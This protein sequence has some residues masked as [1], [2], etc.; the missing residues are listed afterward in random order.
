[1]E[2]IAPPFT[3]AAIVEMSAPF[4]FSRDLLVPSRRPIH[5]ERGD[6]DWQRT[7]TVRLKKLD[8]EFGPALWL[9]ADAVYDFTK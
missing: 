9:F 7:A 1:L 8:S 6:A 4:T 5:G 2:L 3:D